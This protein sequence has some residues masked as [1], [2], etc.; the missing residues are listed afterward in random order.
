MSDL[1]SEDQKRFYRNAAP[2]KKISSSPLT[3]S[4]N[5]CVPEQ[6]RLAG[7]VPP[8]VEAVAVGGVCA[9]RLT[10]LHRPHLCTQYRLIVEF[11]TILHLAFDSSIGFIET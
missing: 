6:A 7:V 10:H 4:A 5:E 11:A 2:K 1:L 8:A 9:A 3:K